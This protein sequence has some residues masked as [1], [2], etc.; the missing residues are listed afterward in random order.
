MS[1]FV[2]I[3]KGAIV[4]FVIEAFRVGNGLQPQPFWVCRFITGKVDLP[5]AIPALQA[6]S[7]QP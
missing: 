7:L 6:G 5:A 4:L 1:K 2:L 3:L